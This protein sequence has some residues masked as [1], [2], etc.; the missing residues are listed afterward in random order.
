MQHTSNDV[1]V[2]LMDAV[3]TLKIRRKSSSTRL[4]C[5]RLVRV[6]PSPAVDRKIH[7]AHYSAHCTFQHAISQ[8]APPMRGDCVVCRR[9]H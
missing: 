8:F 6:A 3:A 1:A 9:H 5:C 7:A 2:F 4:S